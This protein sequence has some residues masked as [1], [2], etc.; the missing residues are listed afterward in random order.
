MRLDDRSQ[1]LKETFCSF[2]PLPIDYL[3]LVCHWGSYRVCELARCLL[4]RRI[5]HARNVLDTL[6]DEIFAEY[7]AGQAAAAGKLSNG[8]HSSAPKVRATEGPKGMLPKGNS[9][10][11]PGNGA[12]SKG[13]DV[14]KLRQGVK[15]G[16]FIALLAEGND[17]TTGEG[18]TD[19]VMA[20]QV[21]ARLDG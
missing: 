15:P 16:S 2:S 8:F 4:Q 3:A 21:N 7:R 5:S 9:Y 17:R 19:E 20:Q 14:G 13:L 12:N 10:K 6:T 18:F 1:I 11:G